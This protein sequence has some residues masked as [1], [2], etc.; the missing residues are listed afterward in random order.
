MDK[1]LLQRVN[2]TIKLQLKTLSD[3]KTG[4]EIIGL[5]STI[6]KREDLKKQVLNGSSMIEKLKNYQLIRDI[7]LSYKKKFD[8]NLSKLTEG[9]DSEIIR[10]LQV[11]R[12]L[13]EEQSFEEIDN[14][15][16]V[17]LNQLEK[18]LFGKRSEIL[19]LQNEVEF[20][21]LQNA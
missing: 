16:D 8:F 9:D 18:D 7:M 6:T 15:I 11:I 12:E 3:I 20:L 21:L 13:D 10:L 19:K 1:E 5:L 17:F 4:K 2:K 14:T